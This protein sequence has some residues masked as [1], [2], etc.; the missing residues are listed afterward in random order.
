MCLQDSGKRY[1]DIKTLA[2]HGLADLSDYL[3]KADRNAYDNV[4]NAALV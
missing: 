4:R 1:I 2:K 3:P